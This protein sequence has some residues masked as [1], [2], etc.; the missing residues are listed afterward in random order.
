V[1][2]ICF[3]IDQPWYGNNQQKKNVDQDRPNFLHYTHLQLVYA[4]QL[5]PL[6]VIDY[7]KQQMQQEIEIN[8]NDLFEMGN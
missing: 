5:S 6:L 2:Q 4:V 7:A 1:V 8:Q 3:R